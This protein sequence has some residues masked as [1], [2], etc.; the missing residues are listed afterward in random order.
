ML[1][2]CSAQLPPDEGNEKTESIEDSLVLSARRQSM[3]DDLSLG[4][5][6][7]QRIGFQSARG[8]LC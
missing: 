4:G 3:R 6:L 8:C 7:L 2:M 1:G 5:R